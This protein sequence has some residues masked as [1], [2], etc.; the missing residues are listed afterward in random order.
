MV[1]IAAS[2]LVLSSGWSGARVEVVG[3]SGIRSDVSLALVQVQRGPP[4]HGPFGSWAVIVWS[5]LVRPGG[6]NPGYLF[7]LLC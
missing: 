7:E 2:R 5:L 4:R 3:D 6:L 1:P